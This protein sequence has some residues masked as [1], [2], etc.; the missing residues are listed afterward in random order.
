MPPK[1]AHG[2]YDH[3]TL[4]QRGKLRSNE[5]KTTRKSTNQKKKR[6][7]RIVIHIE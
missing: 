3:S 5:N 4:P 2:R 1:K 6:E 7:K